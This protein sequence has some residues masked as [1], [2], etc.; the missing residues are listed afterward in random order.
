MPDMGAVV[1][2]KHKLSRGYILPALKIL[3]FLQAAK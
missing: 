3:T 2:E 1:E